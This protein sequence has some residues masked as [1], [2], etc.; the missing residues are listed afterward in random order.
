LI[1]AAL[2][3]A[4][5]ADKQ[6]T[7]DASGTFE[8]VET[9]IYAEANGV[10]RTLN[11]E[12]GQLLHAG[13]TVSY[14]D[15]TQLYLKKRQ[16]EAQIDAVLSKQRNIATQLAALREQLSQAVRD[17]RRIASMVEADAAPPNR[18]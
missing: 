14:I 4:S 18:L 17:Q 9:I 8:A 1:L 12:E 2:L 16:L 6:Q 7:Y 11:V 15:N 13:Q 5:C 3:S 10:I